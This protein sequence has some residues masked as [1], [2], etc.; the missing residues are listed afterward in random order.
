MCMSHKV[1]F[2]ENTH[3]WSPAHVDTN[4]FTLL[5]HTA[6]V[7]HSFVSILLYTKLCFSRQ[8][9]HEGI[10]LSLSAS[11]PFLNWIRANLGTDWQ[12]QNEEVSEQKGSLESSR[13]YLHVML[14]VQNQ[15]AS[16]VMD[17]L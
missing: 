6:D 14:R 12:L 4:S 8:P 10:C 7:K 1:G 17:K 16:S 2:S 15:S 5:W 11:Q 3:L 13:I 9:N